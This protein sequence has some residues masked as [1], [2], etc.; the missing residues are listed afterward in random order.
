MIDTCTTDVLGNGLVQPLEL[1]TC[2][3]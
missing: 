1:T 2:Y 3:K